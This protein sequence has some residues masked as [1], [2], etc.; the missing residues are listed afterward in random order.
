MSSANNEFYFFPSLD[1]FDFFFISDCCA[2]T[3]KIMLDSGESGHSCLVS[4]FRGNAFSFF[5][6]ENNVWCGFVIYGFYYV[7]VCSFY[8]CFLESFYHK[9]ML[10]FV[11]GLLCIYWDNHMVFIFQIVNV[12]YHIYWFANI[13]ESLHPWNKA[14]LVMIYDLL[15]ML[16]NSVC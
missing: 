5:A 8:S 14:H 13:E 2:R 1:S 16:L 9:W 12:V 7:E 6:I 11:K 3:S 10:N 4:D 15:N